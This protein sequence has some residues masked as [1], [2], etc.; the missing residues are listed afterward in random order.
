MLTEQWP[1]N[2]S[3]ANLDIVIDLLKL[4]GL[5]FSAGE[6]F[7]SLYQ[8]SISLPSPKQRKKHFFRGLFT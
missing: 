4:I 6:T 3:R 8:Y 2:W 7:P 1:V 5:D